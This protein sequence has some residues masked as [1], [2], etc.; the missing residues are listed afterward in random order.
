M[1]VN[2]MLNEE[3][4]RSATKKAQRKAAQKAEAERAIR[5]ESAAWAA[6]RAKKLARRK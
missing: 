5:G 2:E 1:S 4:R 3:A 6:K